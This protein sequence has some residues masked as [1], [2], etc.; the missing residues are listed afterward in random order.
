[1]EGSSLGQFPHQFATCSVFSTSTSST[2]SADPQSSITSQPPPFPLPLPVLLGAST[3]LVQN[4][5]A[6]ARDTACPGLTP[7]W[8]PPPPG[9]RNGQHPSPETQC[10]TSTVRCRPK[11][12]AASGTLWRG[13]TFSHGWCAP[14]EARPR[15]ACTSR[16]ARIPAID[17]SAGLPD[18]APRLD[19]CNHESCRVLSLLQLP[20]TPLQA[21]AGQLERYPAPHHTAPNG[22]QARSSAPAGERPP[23][24]DNE[25]GAA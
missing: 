8:S 6:P 13:E 14:P 25:R 9:L 2:N 12:P 11:I 23:G 15:G 24:P 17:G 10:Q 16:P 20:P 22:T 3:S 7:A 4:T 18:R 1:M 21:T 5:V 19:L